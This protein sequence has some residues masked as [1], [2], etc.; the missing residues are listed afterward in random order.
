MLLYA[1]FCIFMWYSAL[2]VL[3]SFL[4]ALMHSYVLSIFRFSGVLCFIDKERL[5]CH[6]LKA[7]FV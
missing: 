1:L 2:Y 3:F 5:N 6:S 7:L 4:C